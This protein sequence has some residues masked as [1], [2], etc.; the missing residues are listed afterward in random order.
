[1]NILRALKFCFLPFTNEERWKKVQTL[2]KKQ[3]LKLL[4][5]HETVNKISLQ[6]QL[7]N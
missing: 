3:K 1:M 5:L 7:Q 6:K 4:H 2:K